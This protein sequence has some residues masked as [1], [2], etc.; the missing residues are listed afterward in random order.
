MKKSVMKKRMLIARSDAKDWMML[1]LE[2]LKLCKTVST[3]VLVLEQKLFGLEIN[4][5][6]VSDGVLLSKYTQA[7]EDLSYLYEFGSF[8]EATLEFC[9]ITVRLE[10][11][12][13]CSPVDSSS[14]SSISIS[15]NDNDDD[16][17]YFREDLS[18]E[19]D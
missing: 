2:Q 3:R 8:G 14:S 9:D 7:M 19:S 13:D 16:C 4:N 5:S 12:T 1:Y 10:D 15:S 18:F 17:S 11:Y 6:L